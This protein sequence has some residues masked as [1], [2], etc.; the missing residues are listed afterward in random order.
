MKALW[1]FAEFVRSFRVRMRFGKHSRAPLKLLRLELRDGHGDCDWVVRPAD[2]WDAELQRSVR[3]YQA[4]SEALLDAMRIREMFFF[5]MPGANTAELRAYRQAACEPPRLVIRG[6]VQRDA[7]G[8]I[9][10]LSSV[11]MRA[12]LFGFQFELD[13]G[14]LVP[15]ES[16]ERRLEFATW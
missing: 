10:R 15:L 1:Q 4:T 6:L 8:D 2:V 12:K 7:P 5:M 16:A 14:V 9:N 11:A 3:D 13:D